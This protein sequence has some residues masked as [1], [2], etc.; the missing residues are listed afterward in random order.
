MSAMALMVLVAA[1]YGIQAAESNA[2]KNR[3]LYSKGYMAA[4]TFKSE[5]Q[6]VS[7]FPFK[8]GKDEPLTLADWKGRVVLL[9]LWATW[10]APCRREMPGLDRLQAE[11]GGQDFEV[12]AL[13]V[14]RKGKDAS[15]KFLKEINV[16]HL[17]RYVD[18][19]NKAFFEMRARGLPA[20][21]LID[22][23]GRLIGRLIGPA[24]WDSEEAKALIRAAIDDKLAPPTN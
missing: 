11:L 15:A 5:R 4:F 17:V 24:E 21:Y 2:Q 8:N 16:E 7:T 1:I 13:S 20:T 6:P 9:N 22:R 10:C 23:K 12:V 14:D 19:T 3:K 18:N